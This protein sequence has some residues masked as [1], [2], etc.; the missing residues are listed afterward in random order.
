MFKLKLVA[1]SLVVLLGF[2]ACEEILPP[3]D[4]SKPVEKRKDTTYVNSNVTEPIQD[5]GILIEDLTGVRCVN[6]P[7]AALRAKSL[8]SMYPDR[9][10]VVGLYTAAPVNLTFPHDNS[11]DLRTE[12]ATNIYTNL[13]SSPPLPAGGINRKIFD[14]QNE[15]NQANQLW[16]SRVQI[17]LP[18]K[19]DVNLD[20]S[21]SRD[22][23]S[24][25]VLHTKQ[26]F[27]KNIDK[28][29]F[30]SIL[31]L[32]NDIEASQSTPTGEDHE[33]VH[34]HVLRHMY[35]PYNGTPLYNK[36]ENGRVIEKDYVLVVPSHVNQDHATF[37]VFLNLNEAGN[38]EVLHVKEV[39]L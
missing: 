32:E 7:T 29:V 19:S 35:T 26:I 27:R 8:D 30:I 16:P 5:K 36:P 24:T 13:Y 3:I 4:F 10:A 31:L 17:E 23:D 33:Y 6:C 9:V 1:F 34:E 28:E 22:N 39:H 25:V 14:G 11:E 38:K 37:V 21:V 20:I 12:F 18:L 15:I 2:S